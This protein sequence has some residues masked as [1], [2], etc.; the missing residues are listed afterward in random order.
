MYDEDWW[1]QYEAWAEETEVEHTEIMDMAKRHIAEIFP[2]DVGVVIDMGCGRLRMG[3]SF[4]GLTYVG[5]DLE[6]HPDEKGVI[7][8]C[9]LQDF[10]EGNAM[11]LSP[12]FDEE[13]SALLVQENFRHIDFDMILK[14]TDGWH[15]YRGT[16]L[17]VSIFS[18]E[19]YCYACDNLYQRAFDE[20]VDAIVASGVY[21]RGT[22][23]NMAIGEVGSQIRQTWPIAPPPNDVY[24]E[25]RI[26]RSV[27]STMFG[28]DV[29]EVWRVM[30]RKGETR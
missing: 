24:N 29:I 11:P 14:N 15:G 7:D 5:F 1:K 6:H 10:L 19:L 21:Y 17:V 9:E 18:A 13:S 12:G 3:E 27:P 2:A 26:V 22:D 20:G 8:Y 16:S 30:T 4:G 28:D 23:V 25:T